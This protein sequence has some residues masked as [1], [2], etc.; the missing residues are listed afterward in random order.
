MSTAP[1]PQ[2]TLVVLPTYNEAQNVREISRAILRLSPSIDVLVVDDNS[3]DGTG[4]LIEADCEQQ[5]RLRLLRRPGK[6]GLGTAYLAGFRFG[7]EH[8][9]TVIVTMDCDWSHQPRYLPDLLKAMSTHDLAI[10][11]RY[12]PG[13]GISNWPWH[14]RILSSFANSYARLLLRVPVRDCTSGFRGY[15]RRVLET[16]EPF[17]IRSS[18]YS[19]LE[20]IVWRAHRAGFSIQEIP[21]VFEQRAAG[22]S[23]IDSSEIYRAAW[24]VLATALRPAPVTRA[25]PS[26]SQ[27][28][29]RLVPPVTNVSA[30]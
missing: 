14:R 10:G 17:T 8:G 22:V 30:D 28:A 19:F 27:D 21:I 15:S 16:V 4:D 9:H 24:H 23:K 13:G 6:L 11:S 2:R 12:V 7:L 3:P 20:E 26:G 1:S 29:E 18:G 5:P 25:L